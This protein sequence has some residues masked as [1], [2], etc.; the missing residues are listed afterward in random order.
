MPG[1]TVSHELVSTLDFFPTLA[2]LTGAP[3]PTD[4]VYD[5][6]SMVRACQLCSVCFVWVCTFV[7]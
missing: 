4:R 7:T 1:Q 2:N 3:L 6:K 5:G